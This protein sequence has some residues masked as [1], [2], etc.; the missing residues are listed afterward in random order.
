MSRVVIRQAYP[1]DAEGIAFVKYHTWLTTYRGLIPDYVLD[2]LSLTANNQKWFKRLQENQN[3]E[4]D[5]NVLVA[6]IINKCDERQESKN[7]VGM[8]FG[9]PQRSS[10]YSYEGEIYAIY[11]LKEYQQLGIG[12]KLFLKM[13]EIL[14]NQ[15]M[16]S[17]LVWVVKGNPST[18]F[19]QKMGGKPLEEKIAIVH[20]AQVHEIG[21]V[22]NN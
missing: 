14:R 8:T 4:S 18:A 1:K 7:I 13:N 21:Y 9:G 22:W 3:N 10:D 19:Y 6:E 15:N 5:F 11:V 12:T 2:N 17:L 20:N 16:N